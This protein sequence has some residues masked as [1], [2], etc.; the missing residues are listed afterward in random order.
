MHN[1]CFVHQSSWPTSCCIVLPVFLVADRD[2]L[3]RL[4]RNAI[5]GAT[6]A[7]VLWLLPLLPAR[8]SE[9]LGYIPTDS[10][11]VDSSLVESPE[12]LDT[13]LIVVV[14]IPAGSSHAE[15]C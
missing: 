13:L 2:G 12:V 7:G 14:R 3:I 10:L 15:S 8:A 11:A 4:M 6:A 9:S 5:G 1:C